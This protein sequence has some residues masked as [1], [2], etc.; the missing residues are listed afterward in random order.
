MHFE[1]ENT[2]QIKLVVPKFNCDSQF[3]VTEPLP[4]KSF[5]WTIVGTGGSGKTSL[6][7]NMLRKQKTWKNYY[8]Q[9]HNLILCMPPGS[10][11]SINSSVFNDERIITEDALDAETLERTDEFLEAEAANGFNTLLVIDDMTSH[12]K[13]GAVL[14]LLNEL[15]NNRRHKRLSIFMLVQYMNAVPLSNRRLITHLAF[16]KSGNTKEYDAIAEIMPIGSKDMRALANY[17]FRE[18]G[19]F[20]FVDV[21]SGRMYRRFNRLRIID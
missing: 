14:R 12:L 7:I 19:D 3:E 17:C 11:A 16:F 9:F 1:E 15:V 8:G 4:T 2:S 10:R 13:D 5:Y 6:L 21:E 20:I 18:K